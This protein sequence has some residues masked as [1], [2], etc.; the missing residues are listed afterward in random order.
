MMLEKLKTPKQKLELKNLIAMTVF[1]KPAAT[2]KVIELIILM[3]MV[4]KP[5]MICYTMEHASLINNG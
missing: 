4:T 5:M 1:V 2:V 3:M